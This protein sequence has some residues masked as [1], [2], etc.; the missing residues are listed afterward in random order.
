M[1]FFMFL[2]AFFK[3]FIIVNALKK[4]LFRSFFNVIYTF[5]IFVIIIKILF[6]LFKIIKSINYFFNLNI[7]FFNFF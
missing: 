3:F 5:I 2:T 4:R 1:V 6:I 7:I